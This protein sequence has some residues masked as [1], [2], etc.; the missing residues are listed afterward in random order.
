MPV[1]EKKKD[2]TVQAFNKPVRAA[3]PFNPS[4]LGGRDQEDH[5]LRPAWAKSSWERPHLN[6]AQWYMSV[7]PS[8]AGKSKIGGQ[9]GQKVRPYLQNNQSKKGL[10]AW[11]KW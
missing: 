9:T 2:S 8:T 5:G 6:R 7:I 11:L 10:E 1:L 4:Y 3:Q